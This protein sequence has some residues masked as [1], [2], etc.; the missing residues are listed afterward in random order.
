MSAGWREVI[1]RPGDPEGPAAIKSK[2]THQ[3][4]LGDKLP[5]SYPEK[6]LPGSDRE[7]LVSDLLEG[8][9]RDRVVLAY[10]EGLLTTAHPF[11]YVARTAVAAAN[12]WTLDTWLSQDD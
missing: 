9:V 10:H 2:F 8:G 12:D 7:L 5:S 6:G 4:P 11:H 3:N 1:A